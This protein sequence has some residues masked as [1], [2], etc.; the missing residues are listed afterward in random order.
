MG[1]SYMM[2]TISQISSPVQTSGAGTSSAKHD[3]MPSSSEEG[4]DE[5]DEE[6]LPGEIVQIPFS[7]IPD[8][9]TISGKQLCEVLTSIFPMKK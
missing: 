7:S 2:P 4:E 8:D 9:A 6:V 1:V 5:G 3:R